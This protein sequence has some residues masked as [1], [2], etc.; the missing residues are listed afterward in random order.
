MVLKNR[1]DITIT[2]INDIIVSMDKGEV[3]ID[4][5]CETPFRCH[6]ILFYKQ[7]GLSAATQA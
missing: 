2:P 7:R 3:T 1:L 6:T 4:G 5:L